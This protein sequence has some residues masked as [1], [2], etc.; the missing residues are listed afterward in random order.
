MQHGHPEGTCAELT[1]PGEAWAA[2]ETE[3]HRT[4]TQLPAVRPTR[5]KI[6]RPRFHL[7]APVACS[8]TAV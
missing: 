1:R 3:I 6:S 2:I 4:N 5:K 7:C 8:S